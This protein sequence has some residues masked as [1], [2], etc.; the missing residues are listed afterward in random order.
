MTTPDSAVCDLTDECP[1]TQHYANCPKFSVVIPLTLTWDQGD[2]NDEDN[3]EDQ[4]V[5]R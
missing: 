5:T 1:A 4:G 2:D 3:G